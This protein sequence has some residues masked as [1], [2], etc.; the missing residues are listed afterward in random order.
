MQRGWP[1]VQVKVVGFVDG[2]SFMDV[3]MRVDIH[4]HWTVQGQAGEEGQTGGK[5]MNKRYR[6]IRG[7]QVHGIH[8][9]LNVSFGNRC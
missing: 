4:S 6:Q 2:Q 5:D 9:K 1:A 8:L 3:A 7:R